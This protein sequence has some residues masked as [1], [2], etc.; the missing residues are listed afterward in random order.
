MNTT[1]LITTIGPS[2]VHYPNQL[3]RFGG[4]I[5]TYNGNILTPPLLSISK[6]ENGFVVKFNSKE[7]VFETYDTMSKFLQDTLNNKG[8]K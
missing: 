1:G 5:L 6:V 4:G 8:E 2:D 7:Y 3:D